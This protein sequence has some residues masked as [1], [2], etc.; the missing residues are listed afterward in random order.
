MP[1]KSRSSVPAI[2]VLG[3]FPGVLEGMVLYR[4]YNRGFYKVFVG[5]LEGSWVLLGGLSEGF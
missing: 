2:E 3:G 4:Q 5:F 1:R